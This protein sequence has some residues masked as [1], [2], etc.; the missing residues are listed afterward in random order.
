MDLKHVIRAE[1]QGVIA[2]LEHGSADA[3]EQVA[4]ILNLMSRFAAQG[5]TTGDTD[6]AKLNIEHCVAMLASVAAINAAE[7]R[8]AVLDAIGRALTRIAGALV[9][10]AV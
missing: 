9:V 7:T 3:S 2:G 1:L 8:Q 4:H 10:A 6:R 5:I